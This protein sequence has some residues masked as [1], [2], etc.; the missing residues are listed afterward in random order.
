MIILIVEDNEAT[1][2]T[3]TKLLVRAESSLEVFCVGTLAEG[4]A[5]S[6]ELKAD[7]TLLDLC[8][9]DVKTWRETAQAIEKFHPPV[10]VVTD[11]DDPEVDVEC[12]KHG[13]QNVFSKRFAL[14]AV[15]ALLSAMSSANMRTIAAE[16]KKEHA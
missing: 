16:R 2:E 8:L 14:K 6:I 9:P 5:K 3:L 7:V 15:T 1:A 4:L 11:M 13:A 12:Y 10:I